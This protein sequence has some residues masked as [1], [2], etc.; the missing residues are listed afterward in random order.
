MEVGS[1]RSD[2]RCVLALGRGVPIVEYSQSGLCTCSKGTACNIAFAVT[3][4]VHVATQ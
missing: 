4:D 3:V 2:S 1:G